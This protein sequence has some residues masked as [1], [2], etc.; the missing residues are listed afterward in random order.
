MK[1]QVQDFITYLMWMSLQGSWL[2]YLRC[3]VKSKEDKLVFL[4]D[5]IKTYQQLVKQSGF[6]VPC[7]HIA[8]VVITFL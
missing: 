5:K 3:Y 7:A 6:R 4:A 2:H 8:L 1:V